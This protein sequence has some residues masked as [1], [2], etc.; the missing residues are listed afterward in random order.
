MHII[1][2]IIILFTCV[3]VIIFYTHPKYERYTIHV[4][5]HHIMD[6]DTIVYPAGRVGVRVRTRIVTHKTKII[7]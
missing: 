4:D 7:L 3:Y 1:I 5:I 2:I 6:N